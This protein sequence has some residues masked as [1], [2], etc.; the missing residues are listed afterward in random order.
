M[1]NLRI[2]TCGKTI[3]KGE[4]QFIGITTEFLWLNCPYCKSTFVVS[5][6]SKEGV[7][8]I[9]EQIANRKEEAQ[10]CR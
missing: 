5:P 7:E 6:Q 2:C 3:R 10:S 4:A 1:D 8:I 9:R